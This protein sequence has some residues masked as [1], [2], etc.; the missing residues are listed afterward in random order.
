[1]FISAALYN[2][3]PIPKFIYSNYKKSLNI[4]QKYPTNTEFITSFERQNTSNRN[5]EFKN[6]DMIIIE[7]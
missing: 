7:W 4:L 5:E 2:M 6:G 1:M 3:L